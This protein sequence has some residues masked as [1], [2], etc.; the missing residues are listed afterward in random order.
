MVDIIIIGAGIT[1][2]S[3]ARELA[4][5]NASI[6]VLEKDADIA[7]GT[8]KANSGIVHAGFDNIPNSLKAKFNVAGNVLFEKLAAE[9]DFPF[10][11]NGALVVAYDNDSEAQ[12]EQLLQRGIENGVKDLQIISGDEARSL[13]TNLSIDVTKA[14]FAPSSGIV[15]P[16]EM[17]IGYAENA[18]MN[19][20]E[21]HFNEP[22]ID[23]KKLDDGYQVKTEANSY[24]AKV[25]INCAGV[26]ADEINNIISDN[27]INIIPRKGEY[28]LLDKEAEVRDTRTIFQTPTKMGKGVLVTPATHGNIIIGPTAVDIDDKQNL[29]STIPGFDEVWQKATKIIP[30]LNKKAV[31]TAFAGL[32]AHSLDNDFIIGFSKLGFYNVAGIES[33][34]LTAA[35]AIAIHVARE[36]ADY[37]QLSINESFN[38]CRKA[39][40]HFN[41]LS[42]Q[43]KLK[44]IAQN[45]KYGNIVCRC[46]V[47][48]EAEIIDAINRPLGARDLDG[49][50]RRTRAGMGRCQGG[51]CTPRLM[52]ILA[53]ELGIDMT[54]VT[55][56]GGKSNIVVGRVKV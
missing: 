10:I 53:K 34:G 2:A 31:I 45:N 19:G 35:P 30:E 21:F 15:S 13:E 44:M 39:I 16:Y 25:V 26:H 4:R 46:E 24:K 3:I 48:S 27:K 8:T 28:L 33:P 29:A 41:K 55:K 56:L 37:L 36:V 11:R 38:P 14:L 49:I 23:I 20:V 54:A 40:I 43:E 51:F 18:A 6:L 50:K 9:L 17:A 5:F 47:V 12:L 52:A 7:S 1:G 22:V 32:R 42:D